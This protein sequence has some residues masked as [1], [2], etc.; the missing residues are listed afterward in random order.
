MDV[1]RC[2]LLVKDISC[3]LASF[4]VKC[5]LAIFACSLPENYQL[6]YYFYHILSWPQLLHVAVDYDGSIVGYVLAKMCAFLPFDVCV[7][8]FPED[9]TSCDIFMMSLRECSEG[10][11]CAQCGKRNVLMTDAYNCLF[12]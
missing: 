1:I 5:S 10:Q 4:P 9:T 3:E 2:F 12:M 8:W 6:K 7:S 11:N